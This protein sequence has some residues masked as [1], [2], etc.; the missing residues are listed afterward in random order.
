MAPVKVNYKLRN[1]LCII[2]C[3]G[4]NECSDMAPTL[5]DSIL[6]REYRLIN[7]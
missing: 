1:V 7:K 6:H 4:L 2:S 5:E 3:A